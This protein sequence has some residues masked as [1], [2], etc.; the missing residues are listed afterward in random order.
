ME[1]NIPKIIH[2]LWIGS[3][4][5]PSVFMN[6]WKNKHPD[7]EYIMW[8][9]DEIVKRNLH[10]ECASKINDMTEINGKADIIR[11]E[12]L[13]HYGGVFIDADSIC[14]E[15]L[16][17]E[18]MNKKAFAGYE[19]EIVRKGLIATGT[20]GFPK[21]HP[22]CRDAIKWI[23]ENEVSPEKTRMMAWRTVGPGMITRLMN[24]GNYNDVTIFPSYYFLPIH[25]TGNN[26]T[27]HGKIYAHQEWGSTKNHYEIM[28]SITIPPLLTR[29]NLHNSVS[30]LIPSYNTNNMLLKDC[31]QSIKEQTGHFNIELVWINDG[32]DDLHSKLLERNLDIFEKTT[33]FTSVIYKKMETN[34]G[35]GYCLAEGLKLCNN[36][37]IIRMDSDDIMVNDRISKQIS[38]LEANQDCVLLGANV[39]FFKTENNNNIYL[40]TTKHPNIIRWNNYIETP[41]EWFMNHP[42]MCFKKNAVLEVGNYNTEKSLCE[43]LELELKILKKYGVIY[44]IDEP[45]LLYR[46]HDK[47]VT[48]NGATSSVYERNKRKLLIKKIIDENE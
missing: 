29:P 24:T 15:P 11:W 20:M 36:E 21:N 32:S 37:I 40:N 9:E 28:N 42:T 1:N 6:T 5:R 2:Q 23:L 39:K 48:A 17:E 33:R 16:D 7:M 18:L 41:S 19:N 8:N 13:Y 44:N 35:V 14:V 12:I 45:L 3:K 30:I 31:L 22:L 47:Q 27:G 4:P 34:M 25:Y 38:F 43:D 26:Y 10:L 46:L